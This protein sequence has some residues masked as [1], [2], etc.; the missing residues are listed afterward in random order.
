MPD[1]RGDEVFALAAAALAERRV[2]GAITLFD[3]AERQRHDPSACAAGRWTCFMLLGRF[4]DAWAESSRIRELGL[5]DPFALWDGSP[6]RGKRTIVRCL[7]GLGDAIQLVRYAELLRREASHVIVQTHPELVSLMR[8]ALFVDD[9]ITWSDEDRDSW[10]AQIEIMELP[11]AFQTTL[12]TIPCGTPYFRIPEEVRRSARI[13]P[14]S[15][16][17]PRI[18]LQWSASSWDSSRSIPL[19]ELDFLAD[20]S[21]CEL[22]SFQRESAREELREFSGLQIQDVSGDSPHVIE[23]AADLMNIDLLIT[24][25]TMLAHLAGSLGRPVWLLLPFFA[26]WRWML[27]REDSPWYP[28]MR[29]FRQSSPGVWHSAVHSVRRE[30]SRWLAKSAWAALPTDH[31]IVSGPSWP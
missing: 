27:D 18:G 20:L 15:R 10:D 8:N 22:F 7:H 13:P 9:A 29:L 14:F 24:V 23:A 12:S 6:F 25:D 3:E 4:A 28:T 19:R 11:R 26:N 31:A 16:S 2:W 17:A 30:L 5:P 21:G 1:A